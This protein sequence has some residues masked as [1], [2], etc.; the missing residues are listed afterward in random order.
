MEL[1]NGLVCVLDYIALP[2]FLTKVAEFPRTLYTCLV[3][4]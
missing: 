4:V 3:G 1:G 2:Q